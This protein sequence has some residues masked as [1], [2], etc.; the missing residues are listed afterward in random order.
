MQHVRNRGVAAAGVA[1]VAMASSSSRLGP[2]QKL[3]GPLN[4]APLPASIDQ[5]ATAQLPMIGSSSSA[6]PSSS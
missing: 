4:Y 2:G 5:K 3:L 6:S 1:A